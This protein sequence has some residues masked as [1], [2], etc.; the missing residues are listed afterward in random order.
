MIATLE[1]RKPTESEVV[2]SPGIVPDS[3]IRGFSG[4]GYSGLSLLAEGGMGWV[5]EASNR[6]KGAVVIKLAKERHERVLLREFALNQTAISSTEGFGELID[7][8]LDHES[9]PFLVFRKIGG[10]SLAEI[11]I[12]T[13]DDIL[14][15]GTGVCEILSRLHGAGFVHGDLTPRNIMIREDGSPV[16]IDLGLATLAGTSKRGG[17][18]RYEAPE[19]RFDVQSDV[20]ALGAIVQELIAKLPPGERRRWRLIKGATRFLAACCAKE[21]KT[22]P[23]GVG[24]VS[25]Q[26][27]DFHR[28]LRPQIQTLSCQSDAARADGNSDFAWQEF[29]AIAQE[30]SQLQ[31]PSDQ[32]E[33]APE[34]TRTSLEVDLRRARQGGELLTSWGFAERKSAAD[35]RLVS[36]F[37]N[38]Y[39]KHLFGRG[40]TVEASQYGAISIQLLEQLVTER[41]DDQMELARRLSDLGR[42]FSLV[43][44][45]I[46]AVRAL[47][48]SYAILKAWEP[49]DS[50]CLAPALTDL[51][52]YLRT[53]INQSTVAMLVESK[54]LWLKWADNSSSMVP[55]ANS[56][57]GRLLNFLGQ[58]DAAKAVTEAALHELEKSLDGQHPKIATVLLNRGEQLVHQR[59]FDEA[60]PFL[61]DALSIR[62]KWY[63][64]NSR[65]TLEAAE[66]C[67]EC[68][69]GAG[70]YDHAY[71]LLKEYDIETTA[72]GGD[73]IHGRMLGYLHTCC[74]KLRRKSETRRAAHTLAAHQELFGSGSA[75]VPVVGYEMALGDTAQWLKNSNQRAVINDIRKFVHRDVTHL[76]NPD[77]RLSNSDLLV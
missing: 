9:K 52:N 2:P 74:V 21:P 27:S 56:N 36:D 4:Q 34:S 24:E 64:E 26:L 70:M 71:G 25:R 72:W 50:P 12:R 49:I 41:R 33:D 13:I 38:N 76:M 40:Q 65:R 22:R 28:Q 58:H 20:F 7:W 18:P 51:A 46:D 54:R 35:R 48:R 1:K 44:K 17:S 29:V 53:G 66:V 57:L 59:R 68:F 19:P 55:T 3:P 61:Q 10:R 47:V 67:M 73:P 63:G 16:L 11:E 37:C 69:L 5:F 75:W 30:M 23:R 43:H 14:K 32:L 8:G 42:I 6:L 77:K 31:C 15:L 39:A 62:R 60:E 45:P